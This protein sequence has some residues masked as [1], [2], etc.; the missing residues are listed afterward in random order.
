MSSFCMEAAHLETDLATKIKSSP[1]ERRA[2]L[3]PLTLKII[4]IAT[5][6]EIMAR[7]GYDAI[8][9]SGRDGKHGT[10]SIHYAD[11]ALDYRSKHIQDPTPDPDHP[12]MFLSAKVVKQQIVD[13]VNSALGPDVDFI[14]EEERPGRSEHFHMEVQPKGI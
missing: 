2:R 10:T 6:D 4:A 11:M 7:Y 9:T 13:E 14:F 5:V 12:A 8:I 3:D 1:R